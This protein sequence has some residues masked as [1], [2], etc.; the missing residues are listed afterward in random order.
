MS[1]NHGKSR[2]K[3][4]ALLGGM[5]VLAMLQACGMRDVQGWHIVAKVIVDSGV[6][7]RQNV[8]T[9][10]TEVANDMFRLRMSSSALRNGSDTIDMIIDSTA[11]TLTSVESRTRVAIIMNAVSANQTG[12]V[13][14]KMELADNPSYAVEDLGSGE[15]IL[16][17]ATHRYRETLQYDTRV[18][19]AGESCTKH[20]KLVTESWVATASDMPDVAATLQRLS[21]G[22]NS[23]MQQDIQKKLAAAQRDRPKG[24]RL[25]QV[26]MT[27]DPVSGTDS[28]T[29]RTQ[30]QISEL[31]HGPIPAADFRVPAGFQVT[32]LRA[33]IAKDTAHAP[34]L[35]PEI[36]ARMRKRLCGGNGT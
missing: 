4:L 5:F 22:V 20:T 13:P 24:A 36:V 6:T 1:M 8:G 2:R 21:G 35:S 30:W 34:S 18:T 3:N 32:D 19:I 16:G 25:R 31:R 29:R 23:D 10:V 26:G 14:V 7:G 12:P 9:M 27:N 15:A 28:L 11:G 17:Q 33:Q